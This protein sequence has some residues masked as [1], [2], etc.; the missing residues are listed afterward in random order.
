MLK[1]IKLRNDVSV[2]RKNRLLTHDGENDQSYCTRGSPS[3]CEP[4][5]IPSVNEIVGNRPTKHSLPPPHV[6]R[7]AV[8]M[9]KPPLSKEGD[10]VET[11]RVSD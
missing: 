8:A 3:N 11:A 5:C 4:I 6:G 7:Q 9:A 2:G 1:G 10:D